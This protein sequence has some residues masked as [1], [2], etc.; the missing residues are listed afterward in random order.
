[1]DKEF[2]NRQHTRM[3]NCR[4][5]SRIKMFMDS[6]VSK[7]FNSSQGID[8]DMVVAKINDNMEMIKADVDEKTW[9][10]FMDGTKI[11][12]ERLS[13]M[14]QNVKMPSLVFQGAILMVE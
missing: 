4:T 13:I 8:V 11:E 3:T 1:M 10:S 14:P 12:E 6:I 2:A 5:Q 9:E 7:L